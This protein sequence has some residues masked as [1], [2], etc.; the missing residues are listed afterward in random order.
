MAKGAG[1]GPLELFLLLRLFLLPPKPLI[2]GRTFQPDCPSPPLSCSARGAENY[3]NPLSPLFSS[4]VSPRSSGDDISHPARL[5]FLFFKP[6][7]FLFFSF[8]VPFMRSISFTAYLNRSLSS[9][10]LFPP[11][12]SSPGQSFTFS[13]DSFASAKY[14]R[15]PL[16]FLEETSS[17]PRLYAVFNSFRYDSPFSRGCPHFGVY[18]F[19]DSRRI[20][21]GDVFTKRIF[22]RAVG[23]PSQK[24]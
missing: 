4:A 3:L 12:T 5:I 24:T 9:A 21:P 10:F 23:S 20:P 15:W 13:M 2:S 6:G 7:G 8:V 17:L 22:P 16:F 11:R 1:R 18:P 19:Q 14:S